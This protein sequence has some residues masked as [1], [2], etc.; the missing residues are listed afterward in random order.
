M[1]NENT[2]TTATIA[3]RFGNCHNPVLRWTPGDYETLR[4]KSGLTPC[5]EGEETVREFMGVDDFCD[6]AGDCTPDT[7]LTDGEWEAVLKYMAE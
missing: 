1:R 3:E 7:E 2:E 4:I 5:D 6:M